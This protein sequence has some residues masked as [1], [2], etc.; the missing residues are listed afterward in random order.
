MCSIFC[1][2]SFYA[3]V[4]RVDAIE[5]EARGFNYCGTA[6]RQTS[7]C[8]VHSRLN[9]VRRIRNRYRN[10]KDESGQFVASLLDACRRAD[11]QL[12]R[13]LTHTD[14][15]LRP[16]LEG[17]FSDA[18]LL[19]H[20]EKLK[21]RQRD[22]NYRL[23]NKQKKRKE[24]EEEETIGISSRRSSSYVRDEESSERYWRSRRVAGKDVQ[25]FVS[26]TGNGRGKRLRQV[27]ADRGHC[28]RTAKDGQ[29]S[30]R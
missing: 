24:E 28:A 18:E 14:P 8:I 13:A 5:A 27:E 26:S 4:D 30:K 29:V 9:E 16:C 22:R 10:V 20:R 23:K 2:S 6:R 15:H 3:D 17:D 1:T 21:R 25:Q 7:Y 12:N 11:Y 19:E